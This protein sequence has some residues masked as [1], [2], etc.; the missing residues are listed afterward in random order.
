MI[1]IVVVVGG[2]GNVDS[3]DVGNG[4]SGSHKTSNEGSLG[5][6]D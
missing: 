5:V 6:T 3:G 2:G 1:V 4:S